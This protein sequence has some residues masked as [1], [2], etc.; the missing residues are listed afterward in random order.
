[1]IWDSHYGNSQFGGNVPMEFFQ[2]TPGYNLLQQFVAPDQTFGVLVF[3]KTAE[4]GA[5]PT[6]PTGDPA[7]T[8]VPAPSANPAQQPAQNPTAGS[9][10]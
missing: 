4:A 8:G 7:T 10:Q 6:A 1:V 2:Q 3:E 5:V 9:G